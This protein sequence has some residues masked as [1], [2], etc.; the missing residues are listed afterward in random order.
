MMTEHLLPVADDISD[1]SSDESSILGN[2]ADDTETD[3]RGKDWVGF[4]TDYFD[5]S[6]TVSKEDAPSMC[7][8]PN[9]LP[10]RFSSA[11]TSFA[12]KSGNGEEPGLSEMGSRHE[13]GSVEKTNLHLPVSGDDV[14]LYYL[15]ACDHCRKESIK[16]GVVHCVGRPRP[17]LSPRVV[18]SQVKRKC[19]RY[20]LRLSPRQ[21]VEIEFED[22]GGDS[23]G[24]LLKWKDE[25]KVN[26]PCAECA[27]K[28]L[29]IC[30][31]RGHALLEL[32][33]TDVR[34]RVRTSSRRP[35]KV[36]MN[37]KGKKVPSR[38][39]GLFPES[40]VHI[41]TSRR[42]KTVERRWIKFGEVC[43]YLPSNIFFANGGKTLRVEVQLGRY[44]VNG[45][46]C[47]KGG[48]STYL[49]SL[50]AT[51]DDI[52]LL[53]S[54]LERVIPP[55]GKNIGGSPSTCGLHPIIVGQV[56]RHWS[57][58]HSREN[59]D[60][61]KFGAEELVSISAPT[62]LPR[63]G[64]GNAGVRGGGDTPDDDIPTV[65]LTVAE[66]ESLRDSKQNLVQ[67][68]LNAL[69]EDPNVLRGELEVLSFPESSP[70]QHPSEAALPSCKAVG[71]VKEGCERKDVKDSE[72]QEDNVEV[73]DTAIWPQVCD[74]VCDE[75]GKTSV[76]VLVKEDRTCWEAGSNT[77]SA[78]AEESTV[79]EED[80]VLLDHGLVR[81]AGEDARVTGEDAQVAGE[82][83]Q[84][85]G[86]R[87]DE[88]I[89]ED[90]K[91]T[92]AGNPGGGNLLLH[93]KSSRV[94]VS[95]SLLP[96]ERENATCNG[97][98]TKD[99]KRIQRSG[100][101]RKT[102]PGE[103]AANSTASG[104]NRG[105]CEE[106]DSATWSPES[107]FHLKCS[108]SDLSSS[109]FCG[110]NASCDRKEDKGERVREE[111][112]QKRKT[113][114]RED[115]VNSAAGCEAVGK[116]TEEDSST[117]G[118]ES[119]GNSVMHFTSQAK[120]MLRQALERNEQVYLE[121][122]L[123][124]EVEKEELRERKERLMMDEENLRMKE[125][126]GLDV[127]QSSKAL[128]LQRLRSLNGQEEDVLEEP[129]Q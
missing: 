81:V 104:G 12:V 65:S 115:A 110:N 10:G 47:S 55:R 23:R 66:L 105:E 92:D 30:R 121:S 21:D 58:L 117:T 44:L 19:P 113:R 122:V 62:S 103:D 59:G 61:H 107:H 102:G 31:Q 125:K 51:V 91:A 127:Y 106:E 87:E 3:L 88:V 9:Q 116:F 24:R 109:L 40:D 89:E 20:K 118:C 84:V 69:R 26:A 6:N 16:M 5:L 68:V 56:Y 35:T 120:S 67:T 86:R 2:G 79:S 71:E 83:T 14:E 50:P 8:A 96:R 97:K 94:D 57:N 72:E 37:G 75:V 90:G 45:E 41:V 99:R 126:L 28:G 82:D 38:K 17:H 27:G 114:H 74:R 70:R 39:G 42:G 76:A 22:E 32:R 128:C 63:N 25:Y 119:N 7:T 98:V 95:R 1:L 34:K 93:H 11:S 80:V 78:S 77:L 129:M 33:I 43:Y 36:H 123:R 64:K 13:V 15:L 111:S 49:A 46:R 53:R 108:K 48:G 85:E 29:E 18:V 101:K 112:R 73:D 100:Q 60:K 54:F 52:L 124:L 4:D